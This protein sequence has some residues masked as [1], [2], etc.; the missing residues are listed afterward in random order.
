MPK[1][2]YKS[3]LGQKDGFRGRLR[4]KGVR[5]Q[6]RGKTAIECAMRLNY[7]CKKK[8]WPL[9][10]PKVG[11]S[12][13]P[14]LKKNEPTQFKGVYKK[15]DGTFRALRRYKGARVFASSKESALKCAKRLNWRCRFVKFP[16][17]NPEAG[18]EK[19]PLVSVVESR[20]LQKQGNKMMYNSLSWFQEEDSEED[21]DTE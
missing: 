18:Y 5:V 15:K 8:G 17:P 12:A 1:T 2:Q 7:L 6:V 20:F 21:S 14:V 9:P 4:R 13:P 16:I 19:P 10:N 3:I 11:V